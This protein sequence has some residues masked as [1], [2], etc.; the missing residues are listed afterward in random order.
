[1]DRPVF[2]GDRDLWESWDSCNHG[3][4]IPLSCGN[5]R[6]RWSSNSVPRRAARVACWQ[7]SARSIDRDKEQIAEY[8]AVQQRDRDHLHDVR[9]RADRHQRAFGLPA[10]MAVSGLGAVDVDELDVIG[11]KPPAAR[12]ATANPACSRPMAA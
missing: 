1:M 9:L 4:S 2:L 12:S 6:W 5:V 7:A 10:A 8:G 3:I 11:V